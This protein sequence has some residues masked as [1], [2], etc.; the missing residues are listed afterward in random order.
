M[1]LGEGS[2]KN[3]DETSRE[4]LLKVATRLFSQQGVAK[5]TVRQIAL[6]SGCNLSMVSYYFEG[7]EKLY[8]AIFENFLRRI[9]AKVDTYDFD[10]SKRGGELT[11]DSV[12]YEIRTVTEIIVDE[13]RNEAE[14]KLL[15]NRE[16]LDGFPYTR[17]LFERAIE[18]FMDRVGRPLEKAQRAGLIR[19]SLHIPTFVMILNRAVESYIIAHL[20]GAPVPNPVIDPFTET[21]SFIDQIEEIFIK[22]LLS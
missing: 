19:P 12:I 16:I 7:K 17:E 10:L 2:E 13:F 11:R 14:V 3:L 20:A 21:N 5:T 4:R 8:Q 22:G 18:F 15:M 1:S 9:S 6:E